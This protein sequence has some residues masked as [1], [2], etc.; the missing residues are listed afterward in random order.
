MLKA[1]YFS[2]MLKSPVTSEQ[3]SLGKRLDFNE[4]SKFHHKSHLLSPGKCLVSQAGIHPVVCKQDLA[5][6]SWQE[7]PLE[8][9]VRAGC[10]TLPG[11]RTTGFPGKCNFPFMQMYQDKQHSKSPF[12]VSADTFQQHQLVVHSPFL[13]HSSFPGD[14]PSHIYLTLPNCLYLGQAHK[15]W[16]FLVPPRSWDLFWEGTRES[17]AFWSLCSQKDFG[18]G[19]EPVVVGQHMTNAF[20]QKCGRNAENPAAVLR[21]ERAPG[22]VPVG[23]NAVYWVSYCL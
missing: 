21:T 18:L 5:L 14:N 22:L 9:G 10:C 23:G 4:Y 15:D 3:E 12:A 6:Q 19:F 16:K 13:P 7:K 20:Q 2:L 17:G 11:C 1:E 8:T